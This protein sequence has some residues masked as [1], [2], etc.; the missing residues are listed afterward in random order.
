MITMIL[1]SDKLFFENPLTSAYHIE[2]DDLTTMHFLDT[3]KFETVKTLMTQVKLIPVSYL[4]S[5]MP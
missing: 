2:V 4:H 3:Q 5:C 1:R